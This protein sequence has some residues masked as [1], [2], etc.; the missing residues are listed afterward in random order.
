MWTSKS[1]NQ[2]LRLPRQPTTSRIPVVKSD[3]AIMIHRRDRT[4]EAQWQ[5]SKV[6]RVLNEVALLKMLTGWPDHALVGS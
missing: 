1:I 4:V 5:F 3:H 6:R 2:L